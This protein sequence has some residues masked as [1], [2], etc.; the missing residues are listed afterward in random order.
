M[1]LIDFILNV[2]GVLLW[3]NW[4]AVRLGPPGPS[5]PLS[6]ASTLKKTESG[7]GARWLS[8]I[9]LIVL[10]VVRAV[11]YWNVGSAWTWTPTLE[12]GV[13]SL[14]FRSDFLVR[15]LLF[16][17]L[18]FGIVLGGFYAW[19][20]LLS[21]INRNG[22]IE[23]PFQRLVRLHLGMVEHWNVWAKLL[24][25]FLCSTLAWGLGST[26]LL[27]LG[28]VPAS[29]SPLHTWQQAAFLGVCSYLVWKLP[30]LLLCFLYLVNSYVYLG[31][32]P[33][34]QY[35]NATGANLL[36]P[37]RSLPVCIGKVDFSPVLAILL[38]V[39]IGYGAGHWLFRL[40]QRLP[41]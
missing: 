30:L 6:L 8:L 9:A 21:I 14:P 37:L 18:S 28:I 25:P 7:R 13:L 33:F 22:L 15:M 40:F 26:G 32:S 4:R 11:F 19:L 41:P 2:A 10:L 31:A 24:L 34:W 5:P 1:G 12:L 23:D 3:V 20:L 17:V 16:S 35:I 27:H 36:K 29:S 39:A 38:L